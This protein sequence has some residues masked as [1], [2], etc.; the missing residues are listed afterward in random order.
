M[1]LLPESNI[2]CLFKCKS[3]VIEISQS[4]SELYLVHI[5]SG[6]Y[7]HV[8]GTGNFSRYSLKNLLLFFY[9][10]LGEIFLYLCQERAYLFFYLPEAYFFRFDTFLGYYHKVQI[11]INFVLIQSKK[12]SYYPFYSV[13]EYCL[14]NFLCYSA[15]QSETD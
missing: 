6:I 5:C 14:S 10:T 9:L 1:D 2:L 3:R 7:I 11:Q 15:S 4:L 8:F 13:S 12:F